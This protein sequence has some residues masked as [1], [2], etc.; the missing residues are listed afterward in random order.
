[1]SG[2]G[3]AFGGDACGAEGFEGGGEGGVL[4][5]GGDPGP[6]LLAFDEACGNGFSWHVDGDDARVRA[7][8][9]DFDLEGGF[10]DEVAFGFAGEREGVEGECDVGQEEFFLGVRAGEADD[11]G[12]AAVAEVGG[13]GDEGVEFGEG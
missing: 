11:V 5:I 4:V 10:A 7:F 8:G 1:L 13:L 12:V 2:E 3:Q 6:G 9:G